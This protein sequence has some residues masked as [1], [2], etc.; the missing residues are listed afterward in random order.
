MKKKI[1]SWLLVLA[2]LVS[3]LPTGLLPSQV[4]SADEAVGEVKVIV[5]NA[6]WSEEDGA[7]WEGVLI[8]KWV[9]IYSDST[10]MSA[11]VE[12]L[13]QEGCSQEGA[14]NNYISDIEGLG[15]K[16]GSDEAGWMGSLNDWFVNEGFAA[17]TV[18]AGTLEDGDEIRIMYTMHGYGEDLGSSFGEYDK[19][20]KELKFSSGALSHTFNKDTLV[21]TLTVPQGTDKVIVTPTATNKAYQVR[22]SVGSTE[23]KRT[24]SVPIENG[25]VIKVTC[26]D[27]SWPS[28]NNQAG[29]AGADYPGVTYTI[30]VV[31]GNMAPKLKDG[32]ESSI[33]KDMIVNNKYELNLSD[34]FRDEEG[35]ELSY[36]V[37][38]NGEDAIDAEENYGYTPSEAGEYTLVFKANDGNIES[39]ETYTVT[40]HIVESIS[41]ERIEVSMPE[42]VLK[43]TNQYGYEYYNYIKGFSDAEFDFTVN[44][45]P[46][47]ASSE[48][49]WSSYCSL[50]NVMNID[51]KG[52]VTMNLDNIT[53][54]GNMMFMARSKENPSVT[55]D[56]ISITVFPKYKFHVENIEIEMD[57][58]RNGVVASSENL[59][60]ISGVH[61]DSSAIVSDWEISN[62]DIIKL[63]GDSSY[64]KGV[65]ALKAG[66]TS[67]KLKSI[68]E[69]LY[70]IASVI[71]KGVAIESVN[72]NDDNS[73]K[74]GEILPLRA[75]HVGGTGEE[76][77]EWS[78]SDSDIAEVD[79]EGNVTA[80]GSGFVEIYAKSSTSVN[81]KEIVGAFAVMVGDTQVPET[82]QIEKPSSI[83]SMNDKYY[84]VCGNGDN[85]FKLSISTQPENSVGD[86]HWISSNSELVSISTDG[87]VH[88][89]ET[90]IINGNDMIHNVIISA[91][92]KIDNSLVDSFIVNITP[93]F[94]FADDQLEI[95]MPEIQERTLA[96]TQLTRRNT[97]S[98]SYQLILSSQWAETADS[99]IASVYQMSNTAVV[100]LQGHRPG[101]TTLS[102][103][104]TL[105]EVQDTI[106][107]IV[108]GVLV[109]T[110]TTDVSTYLGKEE[111][112]ELK[113]GGLEED[114]TF[115]WE[116][117]DTSIATVDENGKVKA[118]GVGTTTIYAVSN[119]QVIEDEHLRGGMIIHVRESEDEPYLMSIKS[120]G[121]KDI[122]EKFN[123]GTFEYNLGEIGYSVW[124]VN[125][126]TLPLYVE[127]DDNH[128]SAKLITINQW[129]D[130]TETEYTGSGT[131]L[132]AP[133]I[134]GLNKVTVRVYSKT[135]ETNY[136]DYTLDFDRERGIND[137]INFITV[138]PVGRDFMASPL[139]YNYNEGTFICG[140]ATGWRAHVTSYEMYVFSDIDYLTFATTNLGIDQFVKMRFTVG[141]FVSRVV[142]YNEFS[143][144]IPLIGETTDITI[145]SCSESTYYDRKQ[146]G[147]DEPFVPENTYTLK[148]KKETLPEE[149]MKKLKLIDPKLSAGHFNTPAFLS[150][151]TTNISISEDDDSVTLNFK[152]SEGTRVYSGIEVKEDHLLTPD[153]NGVYSH[154]LSRLDTQSLTFARTYQDSDLVNIYNFKL[155]ND[156][157]NDENGHDA[158]ID[159]LVPGSQYTNKENYGLYPERGL[160]SLGNF[161]GYITYYY[162]EGI[163]NDPFH[164]YGIDFKVY[165]NSYN[166]TAGFSEPGNVL[167]SED[168]ETWYTLAG[169][170]HYD[171]NAIWDFSVT[172]NKGAGNA[173]L[174]ETSLGAT[175]T[176]YQ[177]PLKDHYPLYNWQDGEE[178]TMTLTGTL[179]QSDTV[180]EYGSRSAAFPA[181]G[182]VDV[183]Y[184]KSEN[185]KTA[186]NPYGEDYNDY[187][188]QFDISWAVDENGM[189]VELDEIHYI[190]VQTA[191]FIDAG[192][193]GE[194][195]TEVSGSYGVSDN[196]E[197]VG[198]TDALTDITINDAD[199]TIKDGKYIYSNPTD[200]SGEL[201][202]NVATQGQNVNVYINNQRT[203]SRTYKSVPREGIVRIVV[204]EGEK[205]PEIYYINLNENTVPVLKEGIVSEVEED[206]DLEDAYELDLST[207]FEDAEGDPLTYT[208]AVNGADSVAADGQYSFTTEVEGE[209]NL[210][211]YANDGKGDSSDTYTVKLNV[212]NSSEVPEVT[213]TSFKRIS[214]TQAE[215]T[216]VSD[217]N[218]TFYYDVTEKGGIEPQIGTEGTGTAVVKGGNTVTVENIT[219]G[220]VDFYFLVKGKNSINSEV[221][222][223][224]MSPYV[225]LD[226]NL[227]KNMQLDNG[228]FFN[229][230]FVERSKSKNGLAIV[231]KGAETTKLSF[232]LPD[233][234]TVYRGESELEENRLIPVR[235]GLY[236]VD[237][238]ITDAADNYYAPGLLVRTAGQGVSFLVKSNG[239][240]AVYLLNLV[241]KKV[242]ESI[243]ATS[244][245]EYFCIGSQYTNTGLYGG[246]PEK[247]LMGLDMSETKVPISL[248]NFGGYVTYYFKEAITENPNNKYGVDFIVYGNAFADSGGASE[249]GNVMVSE[250]GEKWYALAG[251]DYFDDNTEW[252]YSVT[253]TAGENN[254]IIWTDEYGNTATMSKGEHPPTNENY[255]LVDF[256]PD[257]PITVTGTLLKS[258]A[259]DEYGSPSAAYPAWG[260][261]DVRHYPKG[262][263]PDGIPSNPYL[264]MNDTHK[265]DPFDLAWAVDEDGKPVSLNKIHYVKIQT[266]SLV[267][268]GAIGEKSTEVNGMT[269]V[270]SSDTAVGVTSQPE[271]IT[272]NG[273]DVA[274]EEGKYEYT[275]Q[276]PQ[277]Q[278]T[279]NVTAPEANIYINGDMGDE[280]TFEVKP[281]KGIVRVIVQE[282]EKEPLIYY[283][284]NNT[285]PAR[286]SGVEETTLED[287]N[288]GDAYELGLSTIFEDEDDDELRYT[289]AVNGDDAVEADENYKYTPT[290]V[291]DYTLV[292]KANDG[293]DDSTD[294]YTV[295]LNVIQLSSKLEG[296]TIHTTTQ[297]K[298]STVLL[299][300]PTDNYSTQVVFDPDTLEYTLTDMADN[301]DILRF[302]PI[303]EEAGATVTLHYGD[304]ESK[305]ITWSSGM[306]KW[307]RCL[308]P[309]KNELKLVVTPAQGS[310]KSE[311]TYTI[312]VNCVPTLESMSFR[313]GSSELYL[314]KDFDPMITEYTA[315]VPQGD[316]TII[317]NATGTNDG[318]S[319][320]YN[321]QVSNKIN[322]NSI[323][324]IKV[325]VSAGG[326][327]RTYTINLTKANQLKAQ[328]EVTPEDAVV[329]V[330]DGNGTEVSPDGNGRY[331]GLFD[332]YNYAYTVTKYG[333][334]SVSG[335]IPS[336]GGKITVNLT[337]APNDGLT[338]VGAFWKNFRGSDSNM[339][340][341]DMALPTENDNVSLKWNKS[342]GQGYDNA[343]S[344]QI[345]ADKSLIIMS[346]GGNIYKLDLE[347]G[348]EIAKAKMAEV[349]NWG[350]TPPTYAKGM[351][352][353][354]LNDGTIQAFNAKTLESLWV[355]KDSL[356]GQSL[357]PITYSD[358]YIYTGFWNSETDNAN[359]VCISITDEDVTKT[360]EAKIATWKHTQTGGFYWAGSVAVRGTLIVGTDD[361]TKG[362][363][364]SSELYAFNKY[365]GKIVSRLSI[366]GDQRSSIAYEEDKGKIYFT[367]KDGYLYSASVDKDTGEISG[368]KGVKYDGQSTST[369]VIHGGKVFF[370]IGSGFSKGEIIVAD[371]NTLEKLYSVELKGYPQGS[372][373]LSTAYE[374]S[375]G[376]IYLYTTYNYPPG[377]ISLIKI[378]PKATTAK[379]AT[380]K[381]L[382]D[383]AGF[384]EYGVGSLICS[385]DGTIYYKNDAG[386]IL[387]VGVPTP[388]N[389]INL[390][391]SIGKVTLDSKSVII[392]ARS[393][394]NA[395]S[396]SQKAKVAN[397]STLTAAEKE[398]SRMQVKHVEDLINR[399]GT[400]TKNS[401]EA[402]KNARRAYDELS[403][404]Q[405][406]QV[407]NFNMLTAAET[408]FDK[409]NKGSEDKDYSVKN[410]DD[411]QDNNDTNKS[412]TGTKSVNITIDDIKY[413]VSQ[414]TKD[415]VDS[416][417]KLLS[418]D[419]SNTL[420]R[421]FETLTEEQVNNILEAYKAY[422]ALSDDE[423]LFV[424]NYTEFEEV[425]NKLGEVFHHDKESG[426]D[427]RGNDGLPWNVKINI[428]P[429]LV[430]DEEL[431][432]IRETLG[433]DANMM[434][435]FDIY[436]TDMLTGKEYTPEGL[437]R[438]RIPVGESEYDTMVIVHIKDD[439]SYEYIECEIEDGYIIFDASSFSIYGVAGFTGSLRDVISQSEEKE[440]SSNIPWLW[441]G[442]GI[443]AVITL[444]VLLVIRKGNNTK[445]E[446]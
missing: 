365:S 80:K 359:Y 446:A 330:Y 46:E 172:Y 292:F 337:E 182:Y 53:S 194:K 255:P 177:F 434:V 56:Y 308:V 252:G 235:D 47:G 127:Y 217:V 221:T 74:I 282:G 396:E 105:K 6:T 65:T 355:Y 269:R 92:S 107:V 353:C 411:K 43:S 139:I 285:P 433:E 169:S 69:D 289:V 26:G 5:E 203:T 32:V 158:V 50:P 241:R 16:G 263:P 290:G 386:N 325:V 401:K 338:D 86:V 239:N 167:V 402:I 115:T 260:Y 275:A 303:T 101:R 66:E 259:K 23:Y 374:Q 24:K 100:T 216:F 333:Y 427:V 63:T 113:A 33:S 320:T 173:A 273:V 278:L 435:L 10:M 174:Y 409:L 125:N 3:Y 317:I 231:P 208:V 68:N 352:F 361:G 102:A 391:N 138:E 104:S 354:P 45:Y 226:K 36:T 112:V 14:E 91:V 340:I 277:D 254:E 283:I 431:G 416:I 22:T 116:S 114:E 356:G 193:I 97:F 76:T 128:F 302:A 39:T 284:T 204:Q 141:D 166:G 186:A 347:T 133:M 195:S 20:L 281:E 38:I 168:G 154:N 129:D 403:D 272:V 322:T 332:T 29:G 30:N 306:S 188:D 248:G 327:N 130:V 18:S 444:I 160:V 51:S 222:M 90:D 331:S 106:N 11:V 300:N 200:L 262:F 149:E 246:N 9:D 227:M 62:P 240:K 298:D 228:V 44:A 48:V 314:D 264:S 95:M 400:V 213:D 253:Y 440:T 413:E 232:E 70:A 49:E 81:E 398:L 119:E 256:D 144:S 230:T 346:A 249:P 441:I 176:M 271:K 336:T 225:P 389:V 301:E 215:I 247:T 432:K 251:S 109:E 137:K 178:E 425:I 443:L 349:P 362:F 384:S 297:V 286:K 371:T 383:A 438:V 323:D 85:D 304:G 126:N 150:T 17:F 151:V 152:A 223:F 163:K 394:Y 15:E 244:I 135:D 118:V 417:H 437:T 37:S 84:Y 83:K 442:L 266:A 429:K 280:R 364:S 209:Y 335:H 379:G 82:I 372:V 218:G 77:F 157:Y 190:K 381:E 180:D 265:G 64:S 358:G 146:D 185:A 329:K 21:Y 156:K 385:A 142:G 71:V 170:D 189:P 54:N 196:E 268:G 155:N 339:A 202:V 293:K 191:S 25:T 406:K 294:T 373:L 13:T 211:F 201:K 131:T 121:L 175:G 198:Q 136:V 72:T 124:G 7:P 181:W 326:L 357:S 187:G 313:L 224:S 328:F 261:A 143:E 343:P 35:D 61:F 171:D 4:A 120:S 199:I 341:T 145:E 311:T 58:A 12:A 404:A 40:L 397:Y 414:E 237:I 344:V 238:D 315:T 388:T 219:A 307:A 258:S 407:N 122:G 274:L 415:V 345:I 318:Y 236:Q 164:P 67:I 367:T 296:L 410:G 78:S 421:D 423:K 350:Y 87:T 279:V 424:D 192:A 34:I 368:L 363:N 321:G 60:L 229:P 147:E 375:T 422:E 243:A 220:S 31:N 312:N 316:H 234:V 98:T 123:P 161:G 399:I 334:I 2:M 19:T 88:V 96:S 420:P 42:T 309:G 393:A 426:V 93:E 110:K 360:D 148:V 233:G 1:L 41:V 412:R 159:Y 351:I 366:V 380:H 27:P 73:L 395:L 430:T 28:T 206:I 276:M 179:L 245:D 8:D 370:G 305:E 153:D 310:K 57:D 210:V 387:A 324:E 79:H 205:E 342:M 418:D 197:E 132:K 291:G 111:T 378:D 75:Q 89:D 408:A 214:D 140:T 436:F 59:D 99:Q 270:V 299:R 94:E 419:P 287:M 428:T 390:I 405:Q 108:R 445:K 382:Y 369:P 319:I 242:D 55:S 52:H 257:K 288:L 103:Y 267:D 117:G 295:T 134:A 162:E 165:G 207:I 392:A 348:E 184:T 212:V 377:G 183:K 439:G 376:Y 250:D